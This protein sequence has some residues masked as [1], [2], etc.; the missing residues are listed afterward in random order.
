[1]ETTPISPQKKLYNYRRE[2]GLCPKCG[3]PL[4]RKGFYCEECRKK[5][6]TYSR[7]TRELCRQF[8]ICPE[9]RKNKLVGD[10]KICPECLANKAEYRANHPLSDD[11]RRKKQ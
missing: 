2:N 1:M 11:K 9:C 3:K 10:E 7:E 4:D 5:Q 8:K 6:T